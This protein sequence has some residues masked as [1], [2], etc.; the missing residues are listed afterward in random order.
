[1]CI[2]QIKAQVSGYLETIY[3][4][5]GDYVKKGASLFKIKSDVFGEQVNNSKATLNA[6]IAAQATA[7]IEVE[8]LKPL[9]EEKVVSDI[10]LKT[11]QANYDA[12]TAQVAQAKAALGSSQINADFAVI[13]AP[14]SGYIGR[15]PNR[16]GNLV[17]PNDATALTTLSEIDQVF[18]YFSMSEADFIAFNKDRKTDA[19][20]NTV[21]LVMAD[22]STYENKGKLE[23]AS[24]NIERS[25][26]SIALK[27]IFPN[28]DK[29]LRAGGAGRIILTKQLKNTLLLPMA[30]V[31]D[32]QDKFFVFS[33]ADSNKV[34][35]KA[36]E[37]SGKSG[38]N[39]VIK[40]GVAGGEKI[41]INSIDVLADGL[42]V[43]PKV[44]A[45]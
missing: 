27:A 39:Y 9:V 44:V 33:L 8:K 40:S 10:Q 41:A 22:G 14:V 15:I 38:D 11:A 5:E 20:M 26:G 23:L 32:V 36:I 3:V 29:L 25:T 6:A 42:K 2:A 24:G 30:S 45:K 28:P 16:I 18:V 37:I 19:G 21:A 43:I 35:M 31:K 4:K 17:G 7:K 1:M 13:K 12:A 34:A